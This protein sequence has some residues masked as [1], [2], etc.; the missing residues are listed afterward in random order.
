MIAKALVISLTHYLV[1]VNGISR[2]DLERNVRNFTW[3]GRRG[4]MAWE[5][6]ILPVLVKEGGID[7]PALE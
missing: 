6:A 5:S 2:K 1:T 4:Q 7:A 3:N